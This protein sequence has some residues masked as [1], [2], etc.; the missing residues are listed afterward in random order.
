M[1]AAQKYWDFLRTCDLLWLGNI[2]S[3]TSEFSFLVV[4]SLCSLQIVAKQ[5]TPHTTH[6]YFFFFFYFSW[7]LFSLSETWKKIIVGWQND[8]STWKFGMEKD[9]L[10]IPFNIQCS[11]AGKKWHLEREVLSTLE[12]NNFLGG[13]P[14]IL[15]LDTCAEGVQFYWTLSSNSL[16]HYFFIFKTLCTLVGKWNFFIEMNPKEHLEIK[17]ELSKVK[18]WF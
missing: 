17:K 1:S 2:N 15:L 10:S 18:R 4:A 13:S 9:T 3:L 6:Y 14:P 8:C 12:V 5:D 11:K 16:L 7:L